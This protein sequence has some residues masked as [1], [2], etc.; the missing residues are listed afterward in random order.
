[1][2]WWEED[3]STRIGGNQNFNHRVVED[4]RQPLVGSGAEPPI[5][6]QVKYTEI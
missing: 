3:G 5:A 2:Y 4:E 1:M 6:L